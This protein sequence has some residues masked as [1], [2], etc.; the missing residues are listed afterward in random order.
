MNVT[1]RIH[2]FMRYPQNELND[3]YEIHRDNN[4]KKKERVKHLREKVLIHG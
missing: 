1:Q 3:Y 2:S 4:N